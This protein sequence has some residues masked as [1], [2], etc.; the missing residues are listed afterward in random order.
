MDLK[1]KQLSGFSFLGGYS[2]NLTKYTASNIY[3]VG[4]LLRYNPNHTA[5]GSI[6]YS[7]QR[8]GWAKGLNMGLTAF[9]MGQRVAG[10][11]TRLTVNSD[12]Y[13]L[14]PVPAFTQLDASVGYS[15]DRFSVR[16]KVSNVLNVLSY[17][18]HDDNSVNPIAPRMLSATVSYRW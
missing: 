1:T 14:I 15:L 8:T 13:Q 17:Q 4:S 6:Y 7:F 3:I 11:S 12:T 16:A 18:I 10:R 9:Y 5:N 2:Y